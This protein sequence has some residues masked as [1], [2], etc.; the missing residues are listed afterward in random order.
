[1]EFGNVWDGHSWFQLY[2][3]LLLFLRK[4]ITQIIPEEFADR[5]HQHK[6]R[7]N[8]KQRHSGQNSSKGNGYQV[9][10]QIMPEP[11]LS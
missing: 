7:E 1:M 8:G 9:S 11:S 4:K 6:T 10:L 5:Y 2:L 3:Q